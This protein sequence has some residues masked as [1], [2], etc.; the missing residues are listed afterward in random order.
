M[1]APSTPESR[2]ELR[3]RARRLRWVLAGVA[4]AAFAAVVGLVMTN[5]IGTQVQAASPSAQ[6]QPPPAQ[7]RSAQP[8]YGIPPVTRAPQQQPILRTGRS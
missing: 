8:G 3:E 5:P 1:Y 6:D 7:P 2:F 4:G